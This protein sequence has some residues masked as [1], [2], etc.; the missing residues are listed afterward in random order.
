MEKGGFNFRL[1]RRAYDKY[2]GD[3]ALG[4]LVG[5]LA[6]CLSVATIIFSTSKPYASEARKFYNPR[7]T[8]RE[9]NHRGAK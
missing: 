7:F 5:I 8:G 3:L 9:L 4:L 1:V 6:T 2:A